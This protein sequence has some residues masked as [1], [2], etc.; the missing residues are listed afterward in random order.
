MPLVVNVISGRGRNEAVAATTSSRCLAT[1]GSPPVNRTLVMPSLVTAMR[2]RRVSSSVRSSCSPG[3]Q[4]SP[5]AG[6]QYVQRRLQR[7][8]SDTRR[9]VATRPKVSTIGPSV[10]IPLTGR[11]TDGTPSSMM[12]MRQSPRNS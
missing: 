11:C 3:N 1:N 9:S 12:V 2:S 7:S 8:V 10:G 6:M 5:S 4:S